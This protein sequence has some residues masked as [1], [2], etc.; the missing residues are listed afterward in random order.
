MIMFVTTRTSPD[1]R[2]DAEIDVVMSAAGIDHTIDSGQIV[3]DGRTWTIVELSHPTLAEIR[4]RA[5]A[6]TFV[7]ADRLSAAV[8]SALDAAGAAWLDRRGALHLPHR[9][10]MVV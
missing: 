10:N 5:T 2:L 3:V 9:P 7:V 4:P 8:R 1:R 6:S